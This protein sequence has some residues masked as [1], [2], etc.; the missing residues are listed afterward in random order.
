MEFSPDAMPWN[1]LY[2]LMIG[3]ILPRPI[4]WISTVDAEGNPNLAPYSF[5]NAVCPNPPTVLF[6]PMIRNHDGAAKDTLANCRATGE[7]VVNIVGGVLAEKMNATSGEYPSDANEFEIAGLTAAPSVVVKPPRVAESLI[8][9][10]CKVSQIIDVGDGTPGSGS[11]VI[12][13]ILHIHIDESVLMDGDKVKLDV[14]QP[15][16]R[17]AGS[18]Y[19]RVTDVFSMTRPAVK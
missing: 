1:S 15:I 7:F 2:K 8:H 17:L 3:S 19:V 5:F 13:Q 11:I 16:G 18:D 12:G 6:C 14:L 9:Y 10:E 4:G